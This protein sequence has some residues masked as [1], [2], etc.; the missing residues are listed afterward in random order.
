MNKCT[1]TIDGNHHDLDALQAVRRN[2]TTL[3]DL[4]RDGHSPLWIRVNSELY[5]TA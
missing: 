5:K 4:L 3:E 1:M 2:S